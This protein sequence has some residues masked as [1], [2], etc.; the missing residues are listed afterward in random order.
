MFKSSSSIGVIEISLTALGGVSLMGAITLG[1]RN[2]ILGAGG[3]AL[4]SIVVLGA[5]DVCTSEFR[6]YARREQLRLL[7]DRLGFSFR[8]RAA[9]NVLGWSEAF[10]LTHDALEKS[11]ALDKAK[12]HGIASEKLVS[13]VMPKSTN[14]METAV[15]ANRVA[16]FDCEYDVPRKDET[17]NQT[18]LAIKS[19]ELDFP[20]LAI[21]PLTFWSRFVGRYLDV[22][23]S[24]SSLPEGYGF[25]GGSEHALE[26]FAADLH[27]V[28]AD[29]IS[30][31]MGEGF[32]LAYKWNKLVEPDDIEAFINFGLDVLRQLLSAKLVG[33]R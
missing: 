25:I 31:E 27:C 28:I 21:H 32:M 2:Y 30:I 22:V 15:K 7:A 9:L 18:V 10:R 8:P 6:R 3:C 12:S 19:A 16:I 17:W 1:F 20:H 5:R 4:L 11:T 24:H 29:Q 14:V 13:L 33:A 26:A 23:K